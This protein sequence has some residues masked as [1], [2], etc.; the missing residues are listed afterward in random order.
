MTFS[1][2]ALQLVEFPY[3]D[4]IE[5]IFGG[6]RREFMH[7]QQT[8]PEYPHRKGKRL[9]GR[10][11]TEEWVNKSPN[12][13]Y[14][15]N[16]S[17]FDQIDVRKVDRVMGMYCNIELLELEEGIYFQLITRK[18]PSKLMRAHTISKFKTH[19]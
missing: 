5:V 9:D 1:F 2:S 11:L 6:G 18:F 19:V 14:V 3:G 7:R 17:G 10:D 16:K 8:D 4:G 15:W 13:Q 12:S